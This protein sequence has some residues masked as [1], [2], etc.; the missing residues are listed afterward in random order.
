MWEHVGWMAGAAIALIVFGIAYLAYRSW[1]LRVW[2]GQV[3]DRVAD[4]RRRQRFLADPDPEHVQ[5]KIDRVAADAFDRY[6]KTVPLDRLDKY[7]GIGPGTVERVRSA[8]PQTLSGLRLFPFQLI[9]GIGPSKT[10]DLRSAVNNLYAD[11]KKEFDAGDCP[12]AREFRTQ[13]EELK[14]ADQ[15]RATARARELVGVEAALR[16]TAEFVEAAR[17]VT[18]FNYLFLRKTVRVSDEFMAKP[19]PQADAVSVNVSA[20]EPP[21]PRVGSGVPAA[22]S[23]SGPVVFPP[24]K[25]KPA[26]RSTG[27]IFADELGIPTSASDPAGQMHPLLPKLRA[28]AEFAFVI[29]K[30]DGRIAQAEKSVIRGYLADQFG[31]DPRLACQIDPLLERTAAAVPAEAVAL[32]AIKSMT[33]PAEQRTLYRFAERIAGAT[34]EP[35]QREQDLLTRVA[36][37]FELTAEAAPVPASPPSPTAA[38]PADPRAVLQIEPAVQLT[39]ELIRRK[40]AQLSDPIDPDKAAKMGPEFA[41]MAAD[42]RAKLRAAAEALIGPFGESL[43]K[44]A[45]APPSDIRHNPDLDAVLGD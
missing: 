41:A 35:N 9:P 38:P 36:A 8:G 7:P 20:P 28:Y 31:T 18:M 14:A 4:L 11:A 6:V 45:A 22:Q 21:A 40:Y 29:A 30:G 16:A 42:K 25:S 10:Q 17:P 32:A 15:V 12:E 24:T 43:D 44:P 13:A 3:L 1:P 19:L 37:A 26:Q 33:T 27:D 2:K 39:P 5:A 34:G 23:A